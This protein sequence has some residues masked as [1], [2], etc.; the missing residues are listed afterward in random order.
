MKSF[1]P[2]ALLCWAALSTASRAGAAT[3]LLMLVQS[4][5]SGEAAAAES[6]TISGAVDAVVDGDTFDIGDSRIRLAGFDAPERY[7]RCLDVSGSEVHCG[8]RA[9]EF[10]TALVEDAVVSCAILE[11][12]RYGRSVCTCGVDGI[13]IGAAMVAAGHAIDDGRYTPDYS[14]EEQEAKDYR[15]GMHDGSFVTPKAYRGGER[16][17]PLDE[18]HALFVPDSD[19]I[20]SSYRWSSYSERGTWSIRGRAESDREPGFAMDADIWFHTPA[21]MVGYDGELFDYEDL[22]FWSSVEM[23]EDGDLRASAYGDAPPADLS[24]TGTATYEGAIIAV[25]LDGTLTNGDASIVV[26]LDDMAGDARFSDI[27]HFGN[28]RYGFD[29]VGNT[30]ES[31]DGEMAGAFFGDDHQGVGGVVMRPDIVGAFGAERSP[32]AR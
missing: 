11:T 28:L 1:R 13:D 9:I 31:D 23:A 5:A 12:D 14:A 18:P 21:Q 32:G 24:G 17:Q 3:L 27:G 26:D 15:R 22:Y 29:I 7:Q 30:F 10:L 19:G 4:L 2:N 25:L 8:R 16:V 6:A 20:S